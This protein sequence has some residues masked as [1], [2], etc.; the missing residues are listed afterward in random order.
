MAWQAWGEEKF[1]FWVP[2]CPTSRLVLD[3]A[4]GLTSSS[5]T[6]ATEEA[7]A[8]VWTRPVGGEPLWLGHGVMVLGTVLGSLSAPFPLV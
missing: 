5:F 3:W 2:V 6:V 7:L 1:P 4:A 8:G